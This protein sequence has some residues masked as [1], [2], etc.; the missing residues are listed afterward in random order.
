MLQ[1]V[2]WQHTFDSSL[3]Q[4]LQYPKYRQQAIELAKEKGLWVDTHANLSKK[5]LKRMNK[6]ELK[7]EKKAEEDTILL[8]VFKERVT[9]V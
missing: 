1:W 5:D 8:K 9:I 7:D 4:A 2:A 6:K 3:R